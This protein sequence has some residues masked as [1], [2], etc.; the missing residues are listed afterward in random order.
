MKAVPRTPNR[1]PDEPTSLR[2]REAV[3][4]FA[5]ASEHHRRG[6]L[7]DAIRGYARALA[8]NPRM[9]DVYNNMG[10]ALRSQGKLDAAVASYRRSLVLR[11]DNPGVYSNMGNALRELGRLQLAAAS[12]AQAVRRAPKSPEAIYNLGLVLRDMGQV[13]KAMACFDKALAFR[14]DHVDCRWDRALTLLLKGDFLEGF[15]EYEWRWKL[16]RSPPRGF[17]QPL[18]DGKPMKGKT[19]LIHQEQGFGDI[20]QFARY[21]PIVRAQGQCTVIVECQP[22]LVRLLSTV[23]GVSKVVIRGAPLPH[24]D[25]YLPMLSVPR[26]LRTTLETVPKDVPYLYPPELHSVTLPPTGKGQ[27]KVGIAWAGKPTHR[28][29]RNRSCPI[30]HFLEFA[31]VPGLTIYSLQKGEAAKDLQVHGCDALVTDVGRQLEDFADTAAVIHQLDLVISVDTAVAHLAGALGKPVWVVLPLAPDW[32]W[33]A[34]GETSPWYPSMRLFR[35]QRHGDWEDV[36]VR[37]RRTLRAVMAPAA[38]AA[39]PAR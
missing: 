8:L 7:D 32:R 15:E 21:V 23:P 1:Q 11:P 2:D 25:A 20:I 33:L 14:P 27:R 6:Q 18:W 12:H 37:M 31:G 34:T 17:S 28:N 36:F 10:V 39:A 24:F 16:E 38:R 3:R 30:T 22:E 19:L 9:P 13:D 35:Q 4:V 29:D 26:V 5:L